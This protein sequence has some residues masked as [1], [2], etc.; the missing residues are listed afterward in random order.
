MPENLNRTE[1]YLATVKQS[2]HELEHVPE[3]LIAEEL[4]LTA[5]NQSGYALQYVPE[6]L[7][8]SRSMSHGGTEL[9]SRA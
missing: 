7:K 1:L 3:N 2:E 4:C 8:N 5:V 6:G 9:L